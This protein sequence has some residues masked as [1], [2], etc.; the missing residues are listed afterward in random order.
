MG[1]TMDEWCAKVFKCCRVAIQIFIHL[2]GML[3]DMLDFNVINV[4]GLH[5][6]IYANA[7]HAYNMFNKNESNEEK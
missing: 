2:R 6:C 1:P 3:L 7:M 4:T 5:T